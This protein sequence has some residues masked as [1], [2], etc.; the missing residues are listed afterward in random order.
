MNLGADLAGM[1]L[2]DGTPKFSVG[3]I[4]GSSCWLGGMMGHGHSQMFFCFAS[5]ISAG[6]SSSL[7]SEPADTT[8]E[9]AGET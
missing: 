7:A 2:Y 5:P 1:I 4:A 6:H 3:P 9:M 8:A